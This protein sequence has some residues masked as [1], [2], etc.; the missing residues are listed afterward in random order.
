MER[1]QETIKPIQKG[2]ILMDLEKMHKQALESLYDGKCSVYEYQKVRDETTK[3]VKHEEACV[4]TGQPCRLS[5]EK[6]TAVLQGESSAAVGQIAKLFLAP[7]I[8]IKAGSKI[9]VTQAG[10][11]TDYT[12]SGVPAVYPTHQEIILE[13]FERWA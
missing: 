2:G 11:N 10:I 6:S 13:L 12:Y 5:F 7:E 3:L 4:L 8:K 9:C 1:L